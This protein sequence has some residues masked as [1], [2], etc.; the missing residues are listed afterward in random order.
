MAQLKIKYSKVVKNNGCICK[1]RIWTRNWIRHTE[2]D[3]MRLLL[4][5][6]GYRKI[7]HT[8]NQIIGGNFD[9]IV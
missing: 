8:E 7:K 4:T 1:V 2:L 6:V 3:E 9:I 5:V